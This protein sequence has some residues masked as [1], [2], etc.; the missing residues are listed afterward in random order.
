M[1]VA[2]LHLLGSHAIGNTSH[3]LP[4]PIVGSTGDFENEMCWHTTSM[5]NTY[6]R[7][8][9]TSN[10]LIGKPTNLVHIAHVGSDGTRWSSKP[11]SA[12]IS[13]L[14]INLAYYMQV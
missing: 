4:Q 13:R 7:K 14:V 5:L 8:K 10:I 1:H 3:I 12:D 6:H 11:N 2:M 9:S